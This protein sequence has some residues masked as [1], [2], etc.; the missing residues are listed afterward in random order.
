MQDCWDTVECWIYVYLKHEWSGRCILL[1][2][3]LL[4]PLKLNNFYTSE[5]GYL[6]FSLPEFTIVKSCLAPKTKLPP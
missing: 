3:I 6:L 4:L 2:T 5:P 1:A